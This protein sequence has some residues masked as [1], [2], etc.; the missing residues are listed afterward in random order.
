MATQRKKNAAAVRLAGL[1]KKNPDA[2]LL[3]KIA[4]ESM[5]PEERKARAQHAVNVRWGNA[6]QWA[7][8]SKVWYGLFSLENPDV[9]ELLAY[10]RDKV[11]LRG[12]FKD[13]WDRAPLMIE[14]LDYDPRRRKPLQVIPEFEGGR[15]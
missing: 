15:K 10:D 4:H 13:F 6:T 2:A 1:R 8:L 14:Q 7:K 12:R 9:S 5:T 3:S 11:K